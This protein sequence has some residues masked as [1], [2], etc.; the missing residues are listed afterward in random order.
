MLISYS[1]S[2]SIT[3][4]SLATPY[5]YNS[6]IKFYVLFPPLIYVIK[7]VTSIEYIILNVLISLGLFYKNA[8]NSN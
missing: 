4:I 5:N 6:Y 7:G 8:L 3:S 2:F 1:Y